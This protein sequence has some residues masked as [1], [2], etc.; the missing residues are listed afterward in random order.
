MGRKKRQQHTKTALKGRLAVE[1]DAYR[2][3]QGLRYVES[4]KRAGTPKKQEPNQKKGFAV[5]GFDKD[6]DFGDILKAWESGEDPSCVKGELAH[7]STVE[8]ARSFG[9]IFAEWERM[10]DPRLEH[11]DLPSKSTPSKPY[12]QTK[13]FGEILSQ[14]EGKSRVV[15]RTPKQKTSAQ[16]IPKDTKQEKSTIRQSGKSFG[17]LLD[18]YEGK[19]R[20]THE[21]CSL[22]TTPEPV[23]EPVSPQPEEPSDVAW[24]VELTKTGAKKGSFQDSYRHPVSPQ[25]V[26]RDKSSCPSSDIMREIKSEESRETDSRFARIYSEWSSMS[27]EEKAIAKAKEVRNESDKVLPTITE[28]RAMQPQV[29]LDLHGYTAEQAAKATKDFLADSSQHHL[30]K[31]CVIPGKGLHSS[32]GKGVL[33]D[34]AL[35][36]IRLSGL[37]RE[38]YSPKA[39]YGGSGVIWI[40]LKESRC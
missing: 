39:C 5:A 12:R 35:S 2:P 14:F 18:Q 30:E 4:T 40:I 20:D 23:E 32:D 11:D 8:D 13:D 3:F 10:Q 27:D 33:K 26:D 36:E 19:Q 1:D 28:L 29:T 37:V 9:K 6:A 21:T 24:K 16:P 38:A 15:Q 22:P 34:I 17:E 31:I 25:A 7:P